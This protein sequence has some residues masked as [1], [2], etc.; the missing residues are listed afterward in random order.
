MEILNRAVTPPFLV[1]GDGSDTTEE[2]RLRFR[3]VDL[4]RPRLQRNLALRHTVFQSARRILTEERFLEIETPMLTKS[5][6]EGARD[7]L[8][9]SRLSPGAF[10]A[11]PQSPQLFKQL[12]MIG[13]IDRYFQM[14]K[15]FRDEDLRADRQPEFTQLDLEMAFPQRKDAIFAVLERV[16]SAVFRE[17]AQTDLE[18]PF[19]RLPHADAI[20]RF[21]SDKPD[22]RYEM[23]LKDVSEIAAGGGF[24]VFTE[25]VHSGGKVLAISV[26]GA[27]NYSRKILDELQDV[28]KAHGALGLAWIKVEETGFTSP[29]VKHLG[30]DVT[31]SLVGAMDASVGDLLLLVAGKKMETALGA[32]RVDVARREGLEKGGWE[33]L[34]ITDFPLFGTDESGNL[35]SEHHPFTSPWRDHTPLLETA[36]L[37]VLSEAYDLV[38]NGMELGSG[39]IR[40]HSR[41]LQERIFRLLDISAEE[42]ELRF[43]FFL[44]ALEYGAPPHGGFALGM[45]RLV[46]LLA[47]ERSLRDVIAYPKTATGLCPLTDA[48]MPVPEAQLAEL[49]LELRKR[50]D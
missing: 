41:P 15:C 43:G 17:V 29:I 4:R 37:D 7:F 48:P 31:A 26:P 47:G 21:G 8:V 25:A 10:Y 46:M 23:E 16:L 39:S 50:E 44:H 12:F 19:P 36:P 3:Y 14:V 27:A 9:P 24:G 38:L 33:F 5:T 49:G 13:G 40:I 34:W 6:P 22:I 42:A 2:T 30:S 45:D 11:L 32:V 35:T 20:A 18:T 28:A 1:D